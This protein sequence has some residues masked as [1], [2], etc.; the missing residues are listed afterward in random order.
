[1]DSV[2]GWGEQ[3]WNTIVYGEGEDWTATDVLRHLMYAESDMT[4]L[5]ARIQ[6]GEG[7][8][9]EDFDLDRWNAGRVRRAKTKSPAELLAALETSRAELLAYMDTL[10]EEDWEKKGRHGSMMIMSIEDILN[11]IGEHEMYHAWHLRRV[12]RTRT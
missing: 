6:Q 12:G 3:E 2:E 8:V 1:M 7:G 10:E 9:P 4:R 11:R 5:M